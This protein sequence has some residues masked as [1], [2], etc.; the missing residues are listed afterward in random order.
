MSYLSRAFAILFKIFFH[1]FCFASPKGGY[2]ATEPTHPQICPCLKPR[3]IFEK[4]N[5]R[6][7]PLNVRR[8]MSPE[9][10]AGSE[11]GLKYTKPWTLSFKN[12]ARIDACL[13]FLVC[14]NPQRVKLVRPTE[15]IKL[16]FPLVS[17]STS[18]AYCFLRCNAKRHFHNKA[19]RDF[20]T[21]FRR[22]LPIEKN[23]QILI[24]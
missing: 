10:Y 2:L 6:G 7:V 11:T 20:G 12:T 21:G 17:I 4:K 8:S 5:R 14:N 24:T 3:S 22:G 23:I 18:W 15:E 19:Q 16:Q 13:P 1:F 9:S